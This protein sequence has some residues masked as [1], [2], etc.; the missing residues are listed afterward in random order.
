MNLTLALNYGGRNEIVDVVKVLDK[1]KNNIISLK[2]ID[3]LINSHLYT[4]IARS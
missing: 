3:E 4:A 1:V 2:K